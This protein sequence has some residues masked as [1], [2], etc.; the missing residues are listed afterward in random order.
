MRRRSVNSSARLSAPTMAASSASSLPAAAS[1]APSLTPPLFPL[2]LSLVRSSLLSLDA[3]CF[4]VDSTVSG[5]EGIDVLAE[6]LGKGDEVKAYTNQA[7]NGAVPFEVSLRDR[8]DLM[9]PTA[10]EVAACVASNP[11]SF[12][13]GFEPFLAWMRNWF[14]GRNGGRTL[15]VFLVSGGFRPLIDPLRL[16]L[17][18]QPECVFANEMIWDPESGAYKGFDA[19]QPT[20]RSGGKAR[21]IESLVAAH[22]FKHVLMVGDGATDLEAAPPARIVVGYGGVVARPTVE[23][24]AHYFV[25]SWEQLR[26]IMEEEQKESSPP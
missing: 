14:A 21:A 10:A 9:R 26:G 23:A 25:R 11:P 18:L 6:F 19:T 1:A 16:R 17:G 20:S 8:L 15:P 4:D 5:E 24:K 22:G 12:S 3:V 13:P 7:M 2:P